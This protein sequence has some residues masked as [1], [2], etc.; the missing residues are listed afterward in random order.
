MLILLCVYSNMLLLCLFC[1]EFYHMCYDHVFMSI[2][3]VECQFVC[4]LH[5]VIRQQIKVKVVE[6]ISDLQDQDVGKE[7]SSICN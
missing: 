3:C 5:K 2:L 6:W 4:E 7:M 1:A